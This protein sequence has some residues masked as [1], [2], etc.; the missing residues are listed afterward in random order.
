MSN[1]IKKD[2]APPPDERTRD[3]KAHP[4]PTAFDHVAHDAAPQPA[5]REVSERTRLGRALAKVPE[6][7]KIVL[8]LVAVA[9]LGWLA[10]DVVM[11]WQLPVVFAS[12]EAEARHAS[13][14]DVQA[15]KQ[16]VQREMSVQAN[17]IC[18]LKEGMG[19]LLD[20]WKIPRPPLSSPPMTL[21]PGA[22][23]PSNTA[24]PALLPVD[25]YGRPRRR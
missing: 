16:D 15:V 1:E 3:E 14:S 19:R 21:P 11:R 7:H 10:R 20:E 2:R 13:A 24:D 8:G 6:T 5:P 22:H 9:A 12:H 4:V 23:D 17:D 18:W 25:K